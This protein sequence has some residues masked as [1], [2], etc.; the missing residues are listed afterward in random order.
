MDFSNGLIFHV[1][2]RTNAGRKAFYN[3][4][5]YRY[6]CRKISTHVVPH[7]CVLAYC[8]M[9]THFH[10]LLVPRSAIA[11]GFE[12]NLGIGIM[13]RS[14]TRAIQAQ[15]NF[16][17]SLFQQHT[18]AVVADDYAERCFHYIH[19]NPLCLDYIKHVGEWP[20]SSYHEYV[21]CFSDSICDVE[22]G[23]EML[24]IPGKGAVFAAF[25]RRLAPVALPETI[26]GLS[27]QTYPLS[28]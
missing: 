18:K 11:T 13:L 20:Y 12:L 4:E 27:F 8:L 23:R 6:F 26:P 19:Q 2:N 14:Y 21:H 25:M 3:A 17:G 5:N 24:E 28:V 22:F 15:Q 10:L 7:A 16:T 1:F 9:P